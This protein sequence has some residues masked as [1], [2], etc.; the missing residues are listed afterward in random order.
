MALTKKAKERQAIFRQMLLEIH[1]DVIEVSDRFH[2]LD[3]VDAVMLSVAENV[4]TTQLNQINISLQN[5]LKGTQHV[6]KE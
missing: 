3:L 5:R 1:K 6:E 2:T 4:S